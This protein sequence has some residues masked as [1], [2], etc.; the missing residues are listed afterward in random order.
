[1][2]LSPTTPDQDY[3]EKLANRNYISQSVLGQLNHSTRK[4]IQ[5]ETDLEKLKKLENN[6]E[7]LRRIWADLMTVIQDLRVN[8]C[9]HEKKRL[10]NQ[11]RILSNKYAFSNGID[12][13]I[14]H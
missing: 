11:Y 12:E 5:Y 4:R 1:M 14:N 7:A 9:Q 2:K 10:L 6:K 3:N 8:K 13:T